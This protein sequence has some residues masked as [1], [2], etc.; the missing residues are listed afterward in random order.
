MFKSKI[1]SSTNPNQLEKDITTLTKKKNDIMEKFNDA[2]LSTD[3]MTKLSLELG[4]I[5]DDIELK[6]MRWLT[7]AEMME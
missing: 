7:L 6:E 5:N 3:E 2:T 4:K 1:F